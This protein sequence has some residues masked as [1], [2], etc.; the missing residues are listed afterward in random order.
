LTREANE[1]IRPVHDRMPLILTPEDYDRWLDPKINDPAAL[2]PL[3]A[4]PAPVDLVGDPVSPRVNDPRNDDPA[5]CA[6]LES[7]AQAPL[8]STVRRQAPPPR[9][10]TADLPFPDPPPAGRPAR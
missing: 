2:E 8:A 6:P 10:R 9:T 1:L 5:C 4:S 7:N 3:L